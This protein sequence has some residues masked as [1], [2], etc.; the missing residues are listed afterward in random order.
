LAF[1]SEQAGAGEGRRERV[2]PSGDDT[3]RLASSD[4]NPPKALIAPAIG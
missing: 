3:L 2:F 1:E 4:R